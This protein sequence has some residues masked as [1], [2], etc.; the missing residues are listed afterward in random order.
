MGLTK[1]PNGVS[2]FGMPVLGSGGVT[3]PPTTGNVFFVD[4]GIG[5]DA[6]RLGRDPGQPYATIDFAI[7]QTTANNGDQILVL[8]GHTENLTGSIALDVAGVAVIGIGQGFTRPR[9]VHTGTGGIVTIT[10]SNCR[11][12]NIV[13]E[14]S[15]AAVVSAISVSGPGTATAT[16]HTEIDN[17][18]FT[19][20]ATGIEFTVMIALGD[21]AADSAD[22]VTLHDNWFEAENI[23]GCGSALLI[24]DCQFVQIRNNL[25][26]G[27][28]NS[29]AVDGAAG[30]SA[31]LDYVI[32]GNLV[33]NRDT[34][35]ALDLDDSATG[36][37]YDNHFFSGAADAVSVVDFGACLNSRNFVCDLADE[38]AV[39]IPKTASA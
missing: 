9:L 36:L 23:D 18:R 13:H 4:S 5:V 8:P 15:I 24:D 12:S 33:E 22:Y 16:E 2:S 19:F 32:S 14:A 25:F 3:I 21:G 6:P 39:E 7:G 10:A 34:G 26:T 20:D 31:C 35:F 1:F 30:S 38:T 11:W 37:V 28:F 27:D 29:V 17:C